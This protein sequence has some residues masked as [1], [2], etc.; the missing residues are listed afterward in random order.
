MFNETGCVVGIDGEEL[1]AVKAVIYSPLPR[2]KFVTLAS[3]RDWRRQSK[4]H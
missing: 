3:L 2:T 4:R 1:P